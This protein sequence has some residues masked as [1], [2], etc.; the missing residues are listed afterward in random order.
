MCMKMVF[1]WV[2]T[3]EGMIHTY[4]PWSSLGEDNERDGTTERGRHCTALFLKLAGEIRG[5][6]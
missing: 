1:L 6:Y 2:H 5:A 3:Y 4:R